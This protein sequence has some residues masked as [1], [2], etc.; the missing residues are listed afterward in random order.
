MQ[1]LY[2][3]TLHH[4]ILE[5]ANGPV[6][7]ATNT[8]MDAVSKNQNVKQPSLNLSI[9]PGLR[10]PTILL[11]QPT[12]SLIKKKMEELLGQT[13]RL[14]VLKIVQKQR[15]KQVVLVLIDQTSALSQ[16]IN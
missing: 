2:G 13:L 14:V 7:L 6:K 1:P 16:L 3:A 11:I 8:V 10:F 4:K 15:G 9:E 12:L 5:F